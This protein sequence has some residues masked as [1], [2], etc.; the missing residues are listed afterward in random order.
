MWTAFLEDYAKTY[1]KM[2]QQKKAMAFKDRKK[3]KGGWIKVNFSII[4]HEVCKKENNFV[5]KGVSTF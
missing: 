5:L 3:K 2:K 1:Y 4:M